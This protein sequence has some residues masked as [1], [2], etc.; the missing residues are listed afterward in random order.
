MK[1][2]KQLSR[3]AGDIFDASTITSSQQQSPNKR[4][5]WVRKTSIE[6]YF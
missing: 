6:S 5:S 3:S 1:S 2:L 4:S